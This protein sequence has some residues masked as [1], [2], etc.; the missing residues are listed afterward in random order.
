MNF[1]P[2]LGVGTAVLAL[3]LLGTVCAEAQTGASSFFESITKALSRI[4]DKTQEFLSPAFRPVGSNEV[5]DFRDKTV[6]RREVVR[7][8][9]VGRGTSVAISNE[10]GNID[11]VVWRDPVVQIRGEILA[12]AE[13]F[14]RAQELANAI[15]VLVNVSDK[16]VEIRTIYPDTRG[17]GNVAKTVN[18]TIT[19][20]AY[21]AVECANH[22]GDIRAK[23]LEGDLALDCRYGAVELEDISGSVRVRA[24]GEF[25]LR[26]TGLRQGGTFELWRT[27]A[28]FRKVFQTLKILNFFGSVQLEDIGDTLEADITN[29]SGPI[30]LI[31][32]D[33]IQPDVQASVFFGSLK[34]DIPLNPTTQGDLISGRSMNLESNRRIF[35]STTFGDIEIVRKNNDGTSATPQMSLAGDSMESSLA[36]MEATIAEG[37]AVYIESDH[38]NIR[39]VGIDEDVVRVRGTRMLRVETGR[40]PRP[41]AESLT[42]RLEPTQGGLRLIAAAKEPVQDRGCTFYR[43]DLQVECPRTSP[44]ILKQG[45]GVATVQGLGEDISIEQT[46]GRITLEACK[47]TITVKLARGEAQ[48][49]ESAGPLTIVVDAGNVSTRKVYGAQTITCGQ[50]KTIVESPGNGLTVRQRGGDVRI[51]PLDGILGDMDIKAEGGG[52]SILIPESADATLQATARNGL[53]RTAFPLTGEIGRD[54]QRLQGRPRPETDGKFRVLLETIGGDIV[55]D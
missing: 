1:P 9:Q 32:T 18:L 43:F 21:L 47:G 48:I 24:R 45:S 40:D 33:E 55:I 29:D 38:A 19:V 23:G 13:T 54:Y 36:E 42:V 8:L 10:F 28:E 16:T 15:D 12:G 46:E 25:P 3:I 37:S 17:M 7:Q 44:L 52:I 41:V 30:R 20:P 50:G 49:L 34:S 51:L 11:I 5:L 22:F 39:V 35:L 27:Q 6:A 4:G 26:V 53:V 2:R 14:E 31:L